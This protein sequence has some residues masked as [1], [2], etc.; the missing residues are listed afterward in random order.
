MKYLHIDLCIQT[1]LKYKIFKRTHFK[2]KT[3]FQH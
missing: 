2:I 1:H 3:K